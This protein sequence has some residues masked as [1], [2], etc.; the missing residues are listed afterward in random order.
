MLFFSQLLSKNHLHVLSQVKPVL[1]LLA[2]L[3]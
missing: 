3:S 2:K 1:S